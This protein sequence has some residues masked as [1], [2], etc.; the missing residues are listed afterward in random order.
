MTTILLT[1]GGLVRWVWRGA[2]FGVQTA[3][4]CDGKG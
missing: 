2:I 4:S 1:V 3:N